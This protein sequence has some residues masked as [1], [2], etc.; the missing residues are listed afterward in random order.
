MLPDR[1]KCLGGVGKSQG[2]RAFAQVIGNPERQH[3]ELQ[4]A[5]A[6]HTF[7]SAAS[8]APSTTPGRGVLTTSLT[9]FVERIQFNTRLDKD[10]ANTE[11]PR[12]GNSNIASDQYGVNA[13]R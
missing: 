8:C 2:R 1:R 4:H 13:V 5:D 7:L 9:G 11:G 12:R 3:V 6:P 10:V